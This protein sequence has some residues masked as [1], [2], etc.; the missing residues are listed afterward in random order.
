MWCHIHHGLR[1]ICHLVL[2][3]LWNGEFYL[4]ILERQFVVTR[5]RY[6]VIDQMF[7]I[8]L[9]S[10]MHMTSQTNPTFLDHVHLK[11]QIW[12]W[13]LI[14][15]KNKKRN[16]G[17]RKYEGFTNKIENQQQEFVCKRAFK[18]YWICCKKQQYWVMLL[19]MVG[20]FWLW[21]SFSEYNCHSQK[22]NDSAA[23]VMWLGGFGPNL[24][25][26]QIGILTF[27]SGNIDGI[28]IP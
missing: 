26:H 23:L 22:N 15:N 19:V 14:R 17:H 18:L 8:V 9:R 2:I 20:T 1:D 25:G 7:C 27:S 28:K 4:C 16:V 13:L 12:S 5:A 11:I 21:T 3:Y 6:T 10:M 24:F